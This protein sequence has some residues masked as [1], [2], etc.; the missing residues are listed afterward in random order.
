MTRMTDQAWPELESARREAD[1]LRRRAED[2]L[3]L[4]VQR[5]RVDGASWASIGLAL[6]CTRQAA[7][8]R[9]GGL[10]SALRRLDPHAVLALERSRDLAVRLGH[11]YLGTE[12]VMLAL[13]ER[14]SDRLASVLEAHGIGL[15]S[16]R[17][18]VVEIVGL[19]RPADR[20]GTPAPAP[21]LRR[22]L[23]LAADRATR[24]GRL[25]IDADDLVA[26]MVLEGSGVAMQALAGL[27]VDEPAMRA[28]FG[29]DD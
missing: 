7:H 14:P 29:L 23:E 4:A 13:A 24:T 19:S 21:R 15:A 25:E 5:A 17:A 11:G 2:L 3:L 10:G 22:S 18:E 20:M 27:G 6:G 8:E 9:F 12:H 16:L 1:K 26:G 28:A